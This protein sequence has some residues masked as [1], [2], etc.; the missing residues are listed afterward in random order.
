MEIPSSFSLLLS[1][2]LFFYSEFASSTKLAQR[3]KEIR[4]V[5]G[6]K[7]TGAALVRARDIFMN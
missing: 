5:L 3:E 2:S 4:A 6:K 1:P 7:G